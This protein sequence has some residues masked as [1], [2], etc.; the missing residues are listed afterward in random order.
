[1]DSVL[2]TTQTQTLR[3]CTGLQPEE[4]QPNGRYRR[5]SRSFYFG[6]RING[7]MFVRTTDKNVAVCSLRVIL[8]R[9]KQRFGD[10]GVQ[11][12]D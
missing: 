5:W 11:S 10:R 3:Y 6:Y 2:V 8:N 7:T 12:S 4:L 1:M 9:P